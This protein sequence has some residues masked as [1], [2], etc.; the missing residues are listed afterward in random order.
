MHNAS[1]LFNGVPVVSDG[2]LYATH[3]LIT[4]NVYEYTSGL[5]YRLL[6]K[7]YQADGVNLAFSNDLQLSF[8]ATKFGTIPD[9]VRLDLSSMRNLTGSKYVITLPATGF[10]PVSASEKLYIDN[11]DRPTALYTRSGEGVI[12]LY[13]KV[14]PLLGGVP[15]AVSGA[16]GAAFNH[17][18]VF[19]DEPRNGSISVEFVTSANVSGDAALTLVLAD[20]VGIDTALHW[21][22]G[23][24]ATANAQVVSATYADNA[25]AK[26]ADGNYTV[27]VSY[28]GVVRT[29]AVAGFRRRHEDPALASA[30][31]S[32]VM[33]KRDHKFRRLEANTAPFRA[34]PADTHSATAHAVY[35]D[36]GEPKVSYCSRSRATSRSRPSAPST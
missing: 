21:E 5:P 29:L 19:Q 10:T 23:G 4:G 8:S 22:N 36:L 18:L 30:T 20:G 31:R 16:A 13:D 7:P 27:F 26:L 32:A 34:P 12:V 9:D 15:D 3:G 24:N 28:Q 35:G 25:T 11:T 2:E 6:V 1:L 17:S 14:A 33:I